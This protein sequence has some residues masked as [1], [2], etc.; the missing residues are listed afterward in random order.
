MNSFS[1]DEEPVKVTRDSGYSK[2]KLI[3][4]ENR[5]KARKNAHN[6]NIVTGKYRLKDLFAKRDIVV[7]PE[8]MT[9]WYQFTE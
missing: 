5:K 6:P 8:K 9:L 3:S 4:P 7:I 2:L 1:Y